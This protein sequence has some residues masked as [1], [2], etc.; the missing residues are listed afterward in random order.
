MPKIRVDIN[1]DQGV[2]FDLDS[3]AMNADMSRSAFV[4]LMV[5]SMS[6]LKEK[7]FKTFTDYVTITML[8]TVKGVKG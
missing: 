3:M 5:K 6:L 1:M 2:L 7:D 8:N 4:T